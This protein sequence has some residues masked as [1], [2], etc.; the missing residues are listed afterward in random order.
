M[1]N[2]RTSIT[3]NIDKLTKN[4]TYFDQAI[5]SA[6]GTVLNLNSIFNSL[7]PH[8]TGL[9]AINLILT[10]TNYVTQLR[11]HGYHVFGLVPKINILF[12]FD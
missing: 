6:D 3:P 4:G 2:K 10:N 8:K 9:R 12:C 11:D 1:G 5:S 7:R